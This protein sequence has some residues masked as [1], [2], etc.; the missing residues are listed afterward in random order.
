MA[1]SNEMVYR[2]P[3][4]LR[5]E[6]VVENIFTTDEDQPKK[7]YC[8]IPFTAMEYAKEGLDTMKWDGKVNFAS[9]PE[10]ILV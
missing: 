4:Y 7:S 5:A 1:R 8:V 3:R 6:V 2:F 9:Y 10:L